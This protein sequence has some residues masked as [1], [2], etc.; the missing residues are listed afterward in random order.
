[1]ANVILDK[2]FFGTVANA[3]ARF[4][5]GSRIYL[6]EYKIGSQTLK[7]ELQFR[8]FDLKIPDSYGLGLYYRANSRLNLTFDIFRIEYSDLLSGNDLNIGADDECNEQTK[9]YED[10]DG[11]PD[12][13]VADAT[14]FHMGVEWLIKAQKFGFLLPLRF[15]VYTD[16]GPPNLSCI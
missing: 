15:G 12:L 11:H 10:P 7:T 1:M 3:G 16:P 5:L 4:G 6:P 2:L 8:A 9:S 13:T 14:E